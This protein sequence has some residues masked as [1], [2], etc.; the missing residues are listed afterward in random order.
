MKG[1]HKYIVLFLFAA[2]MNG[3]TYFI[4]A[5]DASGT[6]VYS[7]NLM[8]NPAF[9][10]S[11][12]NS[13]LK[14]VYR[15][16]FPG[17]GFDLN[18]IYLGFDTFSEKVHGGLGFYVSE[19]ILGAIINDFRAGANYAYHLR[20]SRDL[21]INAGFNV[22]IIHR[23][24]NRGNIVYPD[25]LDPFSGNI[26]PTAEISDPGSRMV[27]DLGVG[28]IASYK[29][30]NAGISMSHI[31][32]PDLIG[33]GKADDRLNTRFTLHADA[34]FFGGTDRPGISPMVILNYQGS[35]LYGAIGTQVSYNSLAMLALAHVDRFSGLYSMQTG[36]SLQIGAVGI[37]Y[38][39]L[40]SP[41]H[42]AINIPLTQSNL[43]SLSISLNN[44]DKSG[45]MKAI[46]YPKL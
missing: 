9:T 17:Q 35:I 32:R 13:R 36:L 18:S 22:G 41:S 2:T 45:V 11:E 19:N 33:R 21:Y 20:A 27:V 23:S 39:Y 3:F 10:G 44:V 26:L 43:L 42:N 14:L 24:Y 1:L 6:M 38:S 16:Y 34:G 46:K 7:V 31:G 8:S 30:Y 12:G 40:F 29:N 15:D 25:Q 5:Q 4:M 28:F 37:S